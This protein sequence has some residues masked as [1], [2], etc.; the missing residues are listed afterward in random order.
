M[1]KKS[2]YYLVS[3]TIESVGALKPDILFTEAVKIL[4]NKCKS[5]LD[6]LNHS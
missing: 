5:L 6:E 1:N 2:N 4:K 3:V